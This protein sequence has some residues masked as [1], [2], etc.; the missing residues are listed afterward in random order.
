MV[1]E[2]VCYQYDVGVCIMIFEGLVVCWLNVQEC[3]EVGCY[4]YVGEM[5]GFVDVVEVYVIVIVEGEEVGDIVEC[6]YVFVKVEEVVY[7]DCL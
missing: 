7:L 3:E 1:L 2:V 4:W 5:F 6:C